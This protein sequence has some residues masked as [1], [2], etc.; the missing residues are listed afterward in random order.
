MAY[1]IVIIYQ[2]IVNHAAGTRPKAQILSIV[3]RYKMGFFDF[4][5]HPDINAGIA[6]YHETADAVLLDVR[7]K[8]EYREGHVPGSK[9]IPLQEIG[10]VTRIISNKDAPIFVHC[11]S[12]SRSRQ[13]TAL[14]A[15]MGYTNV[16][17]IGGLSSYRGK[18]ER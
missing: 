6:E 1:N 14:L 9:N 8:Q 11:L 15:N 16:K 4:L 7:T 18:V 10:Q 3:R 2:K 13:A 5:R 12:G 17:N